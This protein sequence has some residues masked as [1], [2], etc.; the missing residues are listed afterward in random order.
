M[1]TI[2][3][4]N[5]ENKVIAIVNSIF[6]LQI[7]D[8]VN[9]GWKIKLRFPTE[10]W[11][12]EQAIQKGDRLLITY[13]LKIWKVVR[14]FDWY[15]TDI[16]LKSTE[17]VIEWEN[18]LSYIQYRII[19]WKKNYSNIAIKNVVSQIYNELNNNYT[20]P[21]KLWKNDCDTIIES[22]DFDTGDSFYDILR[23]CWEAEPKLIVRIQNKDWINYLEVSKNPW[24][25]LDWVWEFDVNYT[26]W[27]NIVD[28]SWKDSLDDFYSYMKNESWEISNSEFNNRT[29]LIFEKY[30]EN[31]NLSLPSWSALPSIVVSR[32]TDWWNFDIGDRKNI[33]LITGYDWLPLEY[34]WLIQSRRITISPQNDIKAEIK[35]TEDYKAD[36][37]IL[38]LVLSNLR[39]K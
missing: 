14:L 24:K 39:K 8:E 37:N 11:L 20:L 31:A 27:N 29:K 19:R 38:D 18:W 35:I 28:W 26:R 21:F 22:R 4:K 23:F 30:E 2:Q 7:D 5:W 15:I 9:K 10:S 33:R 17:C 36:T 32:D 12:Q 3:I 13:S 6:S 25:D 34:L 16:T 1:L